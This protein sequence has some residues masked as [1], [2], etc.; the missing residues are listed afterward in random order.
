MIPVTPPREHVHW[1]HPQTRGSRSHLAFR[2][3]L[4]HCLLGAPKDRAPNRDGAA[5]RRKRSTSS[6][7]SWRPTRASG[8]GKSQRLAQSRKRW[9]LL[10]AWGAQVLRGYGKVLRQ[11][12]RWGGYLTTTL[13]ISFD[14]RICRLAMSA[15]SRPLGKSTC[16]AQ[17]ATAVDP[18]SLGKMRRK[19]DHLSGGGAWAKPIENTKV[20]PEVLWLTNSTAI[21]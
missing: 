4:R 19:N 2:P 3:S 18:A 20:K 17:R 8:R 13:L 7:G 15:R 21:V 14:P 10:G 9:R 5:R 11:S 16:S 12:E 1:K 6:A